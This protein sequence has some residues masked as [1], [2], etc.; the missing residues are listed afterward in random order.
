MDVTSAID[1]R[2]TD[3]AE[4]SCC[5]SCGGAL[6]KANI[7]LGEI[8]LDIGSGRGSD[9]L[10]MAD[11]AGQEGFAYGVDMSEGMLSKAR[12]SSE[13]LGV[14]NV[15]F[16]NSNIEK[17]PLEE[18]SVNVIIS[19]C[20]INHAQDKNAVWSEIYR[21]LKP[22]GRFIVSD[23]YSTEPVPEKYASDPVAI[24]ECWGGSVTKDE[25]LETLINTGFIDLQLLEE[26]DPYSKGAIEVSSFTIK[27]FKR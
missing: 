20:T 11:L 13:K 24:S 22:G 26:S 4:K 6:N 27:G 3:L 8:C 19:N 14:N 1:N 21:V 18:N 23:I 2:Y 16:F 10:R 5:L 25:Y 7:S 15:E 12:K 9:V 17:I